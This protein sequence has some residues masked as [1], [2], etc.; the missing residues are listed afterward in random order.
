M[1]RKKGFL[2]GLLGKGKRKGPGLRGALRTPAGR[3]RIGRGLRG[4]ATGAARFTKGVA[5]KTAKAGKKGFIATGKAGVGFASKA[6]KAIESE[7]GQSRLRGLAGA[8]IIGGG[9]FGGGLA[10]TSIFDTGRPRRMKKRKMRKKMKRR[11]VRAAPRKKQQI[12]VT[13]G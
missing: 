3:E 12:T 8:D 6:Q 2:R 1:V 10:P 4:G 13:I 9:G 11:P 5:A 7:K